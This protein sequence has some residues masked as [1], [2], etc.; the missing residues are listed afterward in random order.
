[1]K[2]GVQPD[3]ARA[4]HEQAHILA[5]QY[6]VPVRAAIRQK[7]AD[8][9]RGCASTDEVLKAIQSFGLGRPPVA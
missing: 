1:M 8:M 2:A 3:I 9:L 4:L 5:Q 6:F 7:V